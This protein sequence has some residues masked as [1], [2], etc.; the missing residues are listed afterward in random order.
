[1]ETTKFIRGQAEYCLAENPCHDGEGLW[2]I[3]NIIKAV[4]PKFY[5]RFIHDDI[6]PPGSSFGYHRHRS[7]SP[8]EEWYYC[9]EGEGIMTIDGKDY[10]MR[11]GDI[12]VCYANGSHGLRNTG[13]R[14]LRIMVV[15]A[16]P[17]ESR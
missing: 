4:E 13:E 11:S 16:G 1:M 2:K 10:E 17:L 5:I 6:I 8:L 9:L 7:D 14:D 3:K 12:S 15:C